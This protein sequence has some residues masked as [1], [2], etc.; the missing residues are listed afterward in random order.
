MNSDHTGGHHQLAHS[1]GGGRLAHNR[2]LVLS[3][4]PHFADAVLAGTKTVELRRIR[5][6]IDV[7]VTALVYASSP[8]KALVGTC[9]VQKVES[10]SLADLWSHHK[11]QTGV[12]YNEFRRY[13]KGVSVGV[14]LTLSCAEPLSHRIPLADLRERYRGFR[15]PQSFAYV[16]ADVG[17][18]M[19]GLTA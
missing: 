11:S 13:F 17:K 14:G 5:P 15:P 8:V 2:M 1:N 6:R 12:N 19:L 9:T 4:K 7:P 18:H 10:L 3:L 16:D